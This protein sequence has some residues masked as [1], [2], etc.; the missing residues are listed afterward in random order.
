MLFLDPVIRRLFV[1]QALYWCCA[2]IGITLTALIGLQLAPSNSLATLPLGLLVVGNLISVQ[3]LSLFMQRHGRRAGLLLGASAGVCGGLLSALA[4]SLESFPLFCLGALPIGAYQA[5]AMYYRF[6]AQDAV[7]AQHRGRATAYVLGGGVCAALIAPAMA[8]WARNALPVPFTGAFL[9]IALLAALA[10]ILLWGLPA[11]GTSTPA[12]NVLGMARRLLERPVIRVAILTTA[13]GHGLMILV[14][15]ATPLAM[16][17]CGLSLETSA[18]VIRWHMLGMFLPAFAAGPL[19]DRLG[20][21]RMALLG[22]LILT[23]S[24]AVALCGLTQWFF[25]FSSFLLGLGW[26]LLMVA[27]TTLLAQGHEP[28]ERGHAQGLMELGNGLVAACASFASGALISNLGWSALNIAMLPLLALAL[29]M[30]PPRS[31]I[32]TH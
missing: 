12:S 20:C 31:K 4:I 32:L 30:L 26:N 15:N 29:L 22:C 2:M 13:I 3:P 10:L 17:F 14:M 18:E 8:V 23:A 19:V 5:S 11:G 25:L 6:A 28:G 7:D 21:R 27:G 24:A 9:L 1:A 16:S